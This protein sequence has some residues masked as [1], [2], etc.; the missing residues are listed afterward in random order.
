MSLTAHHSKD[1]LGRGAHLAQGPIEGPK[2]LYD[3]A[4]VGVAI[5]LENHSIPP[6]LSM[7]QIRYYFP[8]ESY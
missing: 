6:L 3:E 2:S 1:C 7:G 5:V 4:K 8:P